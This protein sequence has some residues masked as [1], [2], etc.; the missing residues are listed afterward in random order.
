MNAYELADELENYVWMN[1]N[2][3]R[4]YCK[5]VKDM[6]RQQADRIV[7]LEQEMQEHKKIFDDEVQSY[8][9]DV[10]MFQRKITYFAS[11]RGLWMKKYN[12]KC[13]E[14]SKLKGVK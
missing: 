12:E 13:Q 2:N 3:N 9:N 8:I 6:L 4:D 11:K 14:I 1:P 10:N 7:Q 5:E